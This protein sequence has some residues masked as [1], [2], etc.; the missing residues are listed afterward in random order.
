[1]TDLHKRDWN[2]MK[3]RQEEQEKLLKSLEKNGHKC[4][5]IQERYPM[6]VVWCGVEPCAEGNKLLK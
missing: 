2:D 5:K 1:M 3:K 4:I 6:E